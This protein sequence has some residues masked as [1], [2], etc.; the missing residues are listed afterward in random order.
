MRE[1]ITVVYSGKEEEQSDTNACMQVGQT[2]RYLYEKAGMA[3]CMYRSVGS[4]P[5]FYGFILNM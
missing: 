5:S 2:S 4:S 1:S 3:E